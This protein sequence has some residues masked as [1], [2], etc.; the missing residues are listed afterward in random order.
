MPKFFKEIYLRCVLASLREP[1]KAHTRCIVARVEKGSY[2]LRRSVVARAQKGLFPL[3][4]CV[5]TR[6]KHHDFKKLSK[7][8][9]DFQS[10]IQ[11]SFRN[12]CQILGNLGSENLP[13]RP[14][15]KK[16]VNTSFNS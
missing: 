4:H 8:F 11:F 1:K 3:H 7:I 15:N 5:F 6:D 13:L 2:P 12:L 16:A 10:L 9:T 14:A